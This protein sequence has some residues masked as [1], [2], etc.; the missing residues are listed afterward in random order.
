MF[1]LRKAAAVRSDDN[2]IRLA[3]R[4]VRNDLRRGA[5]ST[6]DLG[7]AAVIVQSTQQKRLGMI[8]VGLFVNFFWN[9]I[10][11]VFIYQILKSGFHYWQLFPLA[12]LSIFVLIGIG[13]F[14]GLVL[15]P[16]FS[17]LSPT[18]RVELKPG[19]IRDG[20]LLEYRWSIAGRVSRAEKLRL[21]LEGVEEATYTRGTDSVT[22][23]SI[24][25]VI[26]LGT[27]E[28]HALRIGSGTGSHRLPERL[29]P[30]LSTGNNR[31]V[32]YVRTLLDVKGLPDVFEE[33]DVDVL[34]KEER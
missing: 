17:L 1:A 26:D 6:A 21:Q 9:G 20:A 23:K 4:P 2:A 18:L 19:V 7:P 5:P 34:G 15:H 28:G 30:S 24:F 13:L 3:A 32:W 25:E 31:I 16:I 12:F 29:L 10:V 22:D 8:L 33:C 27:I 14:F 11:G